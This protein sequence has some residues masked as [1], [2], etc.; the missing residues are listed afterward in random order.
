M[1]PAAGPD[2]WIDAGIGYSLRGDPR[3]RPAR[4]IEAMNRSTAPVLSLDA[5]SGLDTATGRI[6]DPAVDA[7]ATMTLA[8]PKT[9]LRD[10]PTV[11]ELHLAD[12]SVPPSVYERMGVRPV[13]LGPGVIA[14][15]E[16]L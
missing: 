15:V 12:I 5:P 2:L 4:I 11:G 9:G 10:A 6:A 7:T 8:L 1:A 14:R 16:G 3:E 13:T